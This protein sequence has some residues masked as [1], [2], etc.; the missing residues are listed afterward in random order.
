MRFFSSSNHTR[1]KTVH[2]ENTI[3]P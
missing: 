1:R 3:E 2:K